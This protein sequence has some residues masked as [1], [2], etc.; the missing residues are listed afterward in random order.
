MLTKLQQPFWLLIILCLFTSLS[1]YADAPNPTTPPTPKELR[2]QK[3]LKKRSARKLRRQQRKLKR[4]NR[5]LKSRLGKWLLKRAL[6][7]ASNRKKKIVLI[8]GL[9]FLLIGGLMYISLLASTGIFI[10]LIL[11]LNTAAFLVTGL[12][13]VIISL[14]L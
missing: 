3:R 1:A 4:V 11:A 8:I 12:I 6:R 7:K 5:F 10:E 9:V 2:L 13:M 14:A